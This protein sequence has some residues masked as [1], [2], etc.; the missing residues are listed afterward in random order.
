MNRLRYTDKMIAAALR[1]ARG[2]PQA[3]ALALGCSQYPVDEYRRRK[4]LTSPAQVTAKRLAADE[5]RR[6]FSDLQLLAAIVRLG[7]DTAAIAE[8][9]GCRPDVVNRHR[10]RLGIP[11][12]GVRRGKGARDRAGRFA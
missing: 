11:S 10:R 6:S 8:K 4:G 9:L 2:N 12:D 3:A 1:V 5:S 7:D